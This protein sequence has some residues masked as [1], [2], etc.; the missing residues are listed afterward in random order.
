MADSRNHNINGAD[1]DDV[2]RRYRFIVVHDDG[3]RE[4]LSQTMSLEEL[5]QFLR[6]NGMEEEAE[7]ITSENIYSE[8]NHSSDD[9]NT[10]DYSSDLEDEDLED[11]EDDFSQESSDEDLDGDSD[12]DSGENIEYRLDDHS[13]L[14]I[15]EDGADDDDDEDDTH[16]ELE[17]WDIDDDVCPIC[18][19]RDVDI[20]E[21][22]KMAGGIAGG[23]VGVTRNRV[24]KSFLPGLVSRGLTGVVGYA[25]GNVAGRVL[26]KKFLNNRKCAHC[27]YEWHVDEDLF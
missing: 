24:I 12:I 26:D 17:D 27:G 9:Y 11:R 1:S 23:I 5:K 21:R 8:D 4:D 10:D 7:A 13:S 16:E 3:T 2:V 19:S 6:D 14:M 15:I 20:L 22:G 18:G 25:I